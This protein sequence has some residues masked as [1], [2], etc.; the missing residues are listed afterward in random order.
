MA[1][2]PALLRPPPPERR[3]GATLGYVCRVD[4]EGVAW[5]ELPRNVQGPVAARRIGVIEDRALHDA[6]RSGTPVVLVFEDGDPSL[7]LILSVA[8]PAPASETVTAPA[9]PAEP[10][11]SSPDPTEL[12]I[13]GRRLVLRGTER[14][15][16]RCGDASIVLRA[17]GTLKL[18]GRD[19]ASLA[20]RRHRIKGGSVGIN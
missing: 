7:P 6:A 19:I 18:R 1:N 8:T 12:I 17:D 5:V 3:V 4:P 9:E 15:E 14:I 13:D 11:V 20:R 10:E 2:A 16:L